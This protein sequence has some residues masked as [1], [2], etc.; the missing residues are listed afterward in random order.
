MEQRLPGTIL[1]QTYDVRISPDL[2]AHT[3]SGSVHATAKIMEPTDVLVR[4]SQDLDLSDAR[5]DGKP[6]EWELDAANEQLRVQL[7]STRDAGPITFDQRLERLAVNAAFRARA[8]TQLPEVLA[9][10]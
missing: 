10:T 9:S 5:I 4:N 2:E 7:A 1:P 8:A 3:F 6:A